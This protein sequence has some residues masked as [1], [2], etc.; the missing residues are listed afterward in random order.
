MALI[1]IPKEPKIQKPSVNWIM[2][3][4]DDKNPTSV[5]DSIVMPLTINNKAPLPTKDDTE[6]EDIF[7]SADY[8]DGTIDCALPL[9]LEDGH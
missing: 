6:H 7:E 4:N 5:I 8:G 2:G 9:Y 3:V 1:A